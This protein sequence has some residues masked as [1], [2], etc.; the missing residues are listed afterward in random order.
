MKMIGRDFGQ[1]LAMPPPPPPPPWHLRKKRYSWFAS[2]SR[3]S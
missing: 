1:V 3:L 2:R